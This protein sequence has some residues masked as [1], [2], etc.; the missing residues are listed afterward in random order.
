MSPEFLN[1]VSQGHVLEIIRG[2][3]DGC[4]DCV[5]TSPPYFGLRDYGIP[6]VEWP[7]VTFAPMPGL[8]PMTIPAESSVHGLEKNIWAY[9]AHE[10]LVFR[11]VRRILTDHAVLFLNLG[12]TYNSN[13]SWGRGK[14]TLEGR[15]Q[16][17]I[18]NK[19]AG[20][21]LARAKTAGLKPKDI[22]A[23][24]WRVALVLQADGWY[25]R[26]AFP[27]IKRNAMPESVTDRAASSL[28][29]FFMLTKS[30]RYF[31]DAEA[32]KQKGRGLSGG[33]CF[34]KVNQDG[35][36]SRRMSNEENE[37]IRS[38]TRNWRNGDLWFQ[39]IEPPHGMIFCG[40]EVVGID[41]NPQPIS[42]AHFATFGE[43]LITPMILAGCP[44]EVCAACGKPRERIVE[45][46]THHSFHNHE[47]DL[48][49]GQREESN[50]FKGESF[51]AYY[52]PPQTV[53]WSDCGCGQ[54]FRPGRVCDPFLGSGTVAHV[55]AKFKRDWCGCEMNPEYV[56]QI[57]SYRIAEA[58][59]GVSREELKAGQLALFPMKGP[60]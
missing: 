58:E 2:W 11:K 52:Q 22:C 9:V 10:V 31:F 29:Y 5:V 36:G 21:W 56:E 55:A 3:P 45:R 48:V 42:D 14:S 15:P 25:L 49:V 4:I 57:A 20:G 12:D 37:Q 28:E 8:P 19:P 59:T 47:N 1:R 7:E 23:V 54:R 32:V 39:S 40:D 60:L 18:P 53:G 41:C 6:P 27:W 46:K 33:A 44:Q 34:G 30:P 51:Y 13:P 24:P 50:E 16:D 38:G 17:A 43:K 26:S 35:R